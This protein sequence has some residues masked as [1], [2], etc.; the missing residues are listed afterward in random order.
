MARLSRSTGR[1]VSFALTQNNAEPTQ[2]RRLLDL[3]DAANR[4][5]ADVRPQVHGRTV[6]LLLGLQTFHAL[7]F[8]AG[9]GEL[10][11]GLLDWREQAARLRDPEVR[12][13]VLAGASALDDDPI[14]IGFMDPARTY[15]LGDPP[16][17]EP[18]ADRSVD[19]IAAA[20]GRDR[21]EVL[22]D[23]LLGDDGRELLN[24]PV[25]NY[26]DGNLDAA[27]DMLCDPWTVFGLGDGGAH[28]NQTC[29][30]STPTFLLTHWVRD[31]DHGR[32][33]LEDA[34]RRMTSATADL[35]GLSDRGRIAPGAVGDLNVID[36]E[37]L[38]LRRPE[39]IEDL[40]GGAG[41]LIQRA[42]GYVATVKS[43]T[44]TVADGELTG[45]QPGR[46]LRGAR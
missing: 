33:V 28:A 29:D 6:S 2:W 25:L 27:H 12:T 45:E 31:R 26:S 36:L 11:L 41:R 43:G 46:L 5:G 4:A 8:T 40:P 22:Y 1:P 39:R 23:L 3:V 16:Q 24:A 19:S 44:V 30:A 18:G 20:R 37:R 13:R 32:L 10:G 9:W 21:W 35:Y 34:V 38:Q 17:Y 14:V 42:D 15:L 7:Q